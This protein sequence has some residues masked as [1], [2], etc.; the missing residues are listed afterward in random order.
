METMNL[1]DYFAAVALQGLL[2]SSGQVNDRALVFAAF[3]Y[4][5]MMLEQRGKY[6]QHTSTD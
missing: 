6:E 3:E 2:A 4:A 1:R 5:E